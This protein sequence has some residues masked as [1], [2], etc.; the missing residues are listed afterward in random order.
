MDYGKV[1]RICAKIVNIDWFVR[2]TKGNTTFTSVEHSKTFKKKGRWMSRKN[3]HHRC[4]K[5]RGFK[6]SRWNCAMVD[7]KRHALWHA[8]FGN[9]LGDEIMA[10]VN[11]S[12]LDPRYMLM[13]IPRKDR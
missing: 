1:M 7:A 13:V 11:S 10:E 5:S 4:P 6:R 12:L 8:L 9:M 2:L 3:C